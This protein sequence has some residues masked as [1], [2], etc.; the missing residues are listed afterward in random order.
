MATDV[1]DCPPR[2]QLLPQVELVAEDGIPMESGWH[3]LCIHLLLD[4]VGWHLR[5]R[6]DYF[7]AGNQFIYFS[8]QQV[9]NRD[10]RGPD[11]YLVLNTTRE[12]LRPWWCVWEEDGKYPNVIIELLSPTTAVLDRTTKKDIYEQTFRTPNYFC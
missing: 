8:V 6:N 5:G 11:F 4:V 3:L 10:F 2:E 9:P 1:T 12:P 7:A